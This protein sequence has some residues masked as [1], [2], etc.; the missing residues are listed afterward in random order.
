MTKNSTAIISEPEKEITAEEVLKIYPIYDEYHFGEACAINRL[1]L[2]DAL[3]PLGAG[4]VTG[5]LISNAFILFIGAPWFFSLGTAPLM[6][7]GIC[8]IIRSL[9]SYCRKKKLLKTETKLRVELALS[10]E[11]K[12]FNTEL[13]KTKI[14][15][16][17]GNSGLDFENEEKKKI[18]S[19]IAEQHEQL[20]E[21]IKHAQTLLDTQ[22]K[23]EQIEGKTTAIVSA[24]TDAIADGMMIA[25][26][27]E[28]KEELKYL[29]SELEE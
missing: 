13:E 10:R 6:F 3:D 4:L 18:F 24:E 11:I 22:K 15:A 19:Q 29:L 9:T 7:V 27:T 26:K 16:D 20:T 12:K 5:G 25:F 23:I 8:G 2:R 21:K 17:C 1:A 14:L 28:I